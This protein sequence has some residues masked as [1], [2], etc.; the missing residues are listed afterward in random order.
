MLHLESIYI[1]YDWRI[2]RSLNI[3]THK[4][5]LNEAYELE[6]STCRKTDTISQTPSRITSWKLEASEEKDQDYFSH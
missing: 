5:E 1:I 4:V 2:V 6:K 3:R